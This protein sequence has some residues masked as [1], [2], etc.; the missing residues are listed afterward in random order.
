MEHD[1]RQDHPRD[2]TAETRD[3]TRDSLGTGP[4]DDHVES[5]DVTWDKM[6][7]P[8]AAKMLGVTQSAVRKRIQR[9]TIPWDK[10][11]EGRVYVYVDPFE[12][13]PETK[14]NESRD[15]VS[16]QSRDELLEVYKEQVE[17]LRQELERKDTIIMSLTQRI[18]ELEP[19]P[20]PPY[21]PET[22]SEGAAESRVPPGSQEPSQQRSWLYRF[23]FGPHR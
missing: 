11:V 10:D 9:G 19:A 18:P 1:S 21:A 23:F 4:K 14:D 17:F 7:V 15:T 8:E 20:E 6:L 16:G 5:R 13:R 12:G 22:V 3:D 2:V